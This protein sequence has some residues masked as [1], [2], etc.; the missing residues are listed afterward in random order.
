MF[1]KKRKQVTVE[2]IRDFCS[3]KGVQAKWHSEGE[4]SEETYILRGEIKAY[5]TVVNDSR[6]LTVE[7]LR[8]GCERGA[9]VCEK[10]SKRS[11]ESQYKVSINFESDKEVA[12]LNAILAI[13]GW[14]GE[15]RACKK[16]VAFL[17]GK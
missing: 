2:D 8:K 5:D 9:K 3:A 15:A 12:R 1:G 16:M 6:R 17:K 4:L 10:L 13:A 14:K 11:V 7:E